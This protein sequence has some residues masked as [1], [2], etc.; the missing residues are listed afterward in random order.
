MARSFSSGCENAT[1]NPD[2]RLGAKLLIGLFVV[3]RA[4]SQER[5]HVPVPHGSRSRW[6]TPV[7]VNQSS[8]SRLLSPDSTFEAGVEMLE[9]P[10]VVENCGV[11]T[12][13]LSASR[14]AC[15]S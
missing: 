3:E 13:R 12:L 15:T 9:R 4:A 14:A 2:C 10:S 8:T 11:Y 5:L 1:W 6:R 7:D